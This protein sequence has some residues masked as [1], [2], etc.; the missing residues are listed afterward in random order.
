MKKKKVHVC[1][2]FIY[3]FISRNKAS[4]WNKVNTKKYLL[5]ET[6]THTNLTVSLA[7]LW[8]KTRPLG[9]NFHLPKSLLLLSL[10][11]LVTKNSKSPFNQKFLSVLGNNSFDNLLIV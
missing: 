3:Y 2:Y 9:L 10:K 5:E 7:Y 1:V 8:D 4:S 11:L 6:H